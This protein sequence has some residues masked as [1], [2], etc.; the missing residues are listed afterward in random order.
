MKKWIAAIMALLMLTL[1]G[2]GIAEAAKEAG[3]RV[4]REGKYIIGEDIEAG[5]Y[6]LTCT[7]TAGG[8]DER[9]LCLAGQR[10]WRP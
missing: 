3:G 2:V 6:T 7:A 5:R 10:V 9:R 8:G 4:L 1:A